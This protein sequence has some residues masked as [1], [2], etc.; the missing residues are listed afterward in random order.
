MS[1]E[2]MKGHKME[3]FMVQVSF[4]G[5][6]ILSMMTFGILFVAYVGPYYNATMAAFYDRVR[7]SYDCKCDNGSF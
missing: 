6:F 1:G 4:I 3:L 2:M 5:W 7:Y